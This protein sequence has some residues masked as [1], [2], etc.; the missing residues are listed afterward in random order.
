MKAW[1]LA[2]RPKTLSAGIVPVTVASALA[3]RWGS[4]QWGVWVA[5]LGATILLQVGTN[6]VNDA[7]DFLRGADTKDRLGPPRMAQLGLMS[8][9]ALF[10]GA[11]LCF[12][13]AFLAGLYLISLAGSPILWIGIVSILCAVAYTAGPF[14]LAYLGLGDVFVLLF[15]G[16]VAVGGTLFAHLGILPKQFW[17][18]G[19][20]VGFHGVSLI[21][22]NNIRDIE[23]DAKVNKKTL[24]VRLG[25]K[26]SRLYYSITLF[27]PYIFCFL[28]LMETPTAAA[29]VFLSLPLA[30]KNAQRV[31]AAQNAKDYLALLP[32]TA[33]LQM[34][35]GFLMTLGILCF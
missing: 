35:F 34:V 5:A 26:K 16:L 18:A 3:W 22:V 20:C 28:T 25:E 33:K 10:F 23:T 4:F 29:P 21:A 31:F 2:A 11:A 24:A 13:G 6:Y 17:M 1:I 32:E 15:F 30:Y 8:P 7:S 27:L 9:R 12:F 14:P 19:L